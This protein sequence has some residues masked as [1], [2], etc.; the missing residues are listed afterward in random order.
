[1]RIA[2]IS[3]DAQS[4]AARG[5]PALFQLVR[6][7]SRRWLRDDHLNPDDHALDILVLEATDAAARTTTPSVAA[8]AAQLGLDR[9]GAS[10]LIA[11]AAEHGYLLRRTQPAD[12]RRAELTITR[13]GRSL[14]NAARR[15]QSAT[16]LE[17]VAG[18]DPSDRDAFAGYLVKLADTVLMEAAND[19]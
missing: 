19:D 2:R 9:S 17:L 8:V 13:T 14:L 15:W 11:A 3:N 1:V 5:G 6:F 18:W 12:A 16:F 10:R 4:L 7:W